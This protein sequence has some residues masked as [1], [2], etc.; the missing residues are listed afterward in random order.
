MQFNTSILRRT[1]K[2]TYENRLPNAPPRRT[3]SY[4]ESIGL[5]KEAL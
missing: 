5:A 2:R 1:I 4:L 3:M